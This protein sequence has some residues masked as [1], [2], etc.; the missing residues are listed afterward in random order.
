MAQPFLP[1]VKNQYI[2]EMNGAVLPQLGQVYT[3]SVFGKIIEIIGTA[4]CIIV[5]VASLAIFY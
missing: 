5:T 1:K 2:N 4:P 3:T